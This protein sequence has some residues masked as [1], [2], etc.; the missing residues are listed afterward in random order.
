MRFTCTLIII[1]ALLDLPAIL[2][3][4]NCLLPAEYAFTMILRERKQQ[5]I[6]MKRRHALS[7][8]RL[9]LKLSATSMLRLGLE[10]VTL[11]LGLGALSALRIEL[12][13]LKH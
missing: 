2:L 3:S 11:T 5:Q 6:T 12:G 10:I 9:G 8:L 13:R 7:A 1:S 4:T